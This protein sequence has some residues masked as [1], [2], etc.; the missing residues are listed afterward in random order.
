VLYLRLLRGGKKATPT[1]ALLTEQQLLEKKKSLMGYGVAKLL[2]G[3]H[4]NGGHKA[5]GLKII[6]N[7]GIK[8][9][10]IRTILMGLLIGFG[11]VR[12]F[13][14]IVNVFQIVKA[15]VV[16]KVFL[17][18]LNCHICY[19]DATFIAVFVNAAI[20]NN[21]GGYDKLNKVSFFG[22]LFWQ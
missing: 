13:N 3:Q 16:I 18:F 12:T 9:F 15:K 4:L 21:S 19:F 7:C 20:G 14:V 22:L 6:L 17:D 2:L 8:L 5:N 11:V 1:E 10:H